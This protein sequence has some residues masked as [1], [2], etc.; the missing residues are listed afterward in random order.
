MLNMLGMDGRM[1]RLRPAYVRDARYDFLPRE[2]RVT[3]VRYARR[4]DDNGRI[5]AFREGTQPIIERVRVQNDILSADL[6]AKD[7]VNA[8]EIVG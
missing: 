3:R 5:L 8:Y 4:E 2:A 1:F 6:H 7:F